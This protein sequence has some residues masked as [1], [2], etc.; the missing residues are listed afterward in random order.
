MKYEIQCPVCFSSKCRINPR[1]ASFLNFRDYQKLYVCHHCGHM[2]RIPSIAEDHLLT[3]KYELEKGIVTYGQFTIHNAN[4]IP[5]R[6]IQ[7]ISRYA[8]PGAKIL[9]FGAGNGAFLNFCRKR[10]YDAWGVE[11]QLEKIPDHLRTYVK[12]DIQEFDFLFDIIQMNHVLEHIRDP[13]GML[14]QI[15]QKMNKGAVLLIEIPNEIRSMTSFIKRLLKKN[16]ISATS[17]YEHEHYF[18]LKS[19]RTLLQNVC[20]RNIHTETPYVGGK[21]GPARKLISSLGYGDVIFAVAK[22]MD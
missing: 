22:T 12:Q 15:Q 21:L 5:E 13:L 10:G 16:S 11:I 9:D 20:F 4:A 17:L 7:R 14:K 3:K 18:T 19:L 8:F 6:N 2:W 1:Y